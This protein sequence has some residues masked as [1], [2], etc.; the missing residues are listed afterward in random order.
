[1]QLKE[2]HR[3][4]SNLDRESG[5]SQKVVSALPLKADVCGAMAHVGFGPIADIAPALSK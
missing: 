3:S 2:L 4:G 5:H 1:M